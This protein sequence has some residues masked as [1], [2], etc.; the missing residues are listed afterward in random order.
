MRF[1]EFI[2][3]V[4]YTE[5]WWN[6]DANSPLGHCFHDI[7][8]VNRYLEVQLHSAKRQDMNMLTK[9]KTHDYLEQIDTFWNSN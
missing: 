6:V 1:K 4:E 3:N 2:Q 9:G 5:R 8:P 7:T